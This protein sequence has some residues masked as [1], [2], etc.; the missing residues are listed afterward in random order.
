MENIPLS[1]F[2][3]PLKG[4]QT[5]TAMTA[6]SSKKLPKK[7]SKFRSPKSCTLYAK[8]EPKATPQNDQNLQK[9]VEMLSRILPEWIW[10]PTLEKVVS[11]SLPDMPKCVENTAPAMLFTYPRECLQSPFGLHFGSL[12]APFSGPWAFKSRLR[13][14]KK[15]FRKNLKKRPC[16]RCSNTSKMTSKMG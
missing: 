14:E 13:V 4:P 16:K 6:G 7:S 3:K 5:G 2:R 11:R 1:H 15:A 8:M 12:L 9:S 10:R